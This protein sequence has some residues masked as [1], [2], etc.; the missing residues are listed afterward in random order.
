[1]FLALTG[2]ESGLLGSE[3]YAENPVFP[4]RETV[5]VLNLDT[6]HIGGPTRD[7]TCSASGTRIWRSTRAPWRC[8]RAAR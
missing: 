4:L 6:L 2:A 8:C 5:A 7:V 1:M 3:Y